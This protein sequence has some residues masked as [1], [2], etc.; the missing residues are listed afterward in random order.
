[1]FD[2]DEAR[3]MAKTPVILNNLFA[4]ARIPAMA[5]V[6]L[7]Q[8]YDQRET[9]LCCSRSMN[10]FLV[11][12]L[13]PWLR[14]QYGIRTEPGRVIV[15]GASLGGLAAAFAALEHPLVFGRV[16]SQSGAFWWGKT[17]S[18][19]QWFTAELASKPKQ[20]VKFYLDVGLMETNGGTL[21]QIA[22]NRRL[23]KVLRDKGYQVIYREFNGPHAFAC[24]RAGLADALVSLLAL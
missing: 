13:M 19:H 23:L 22:T 11:N 9:D 21:S 24:W 8:P 18:E 1:M 12:E 2:G 14:R 6:F 7:I 10:R 5:A 15:A 20:N 16:L 17:D 3:D 4:E